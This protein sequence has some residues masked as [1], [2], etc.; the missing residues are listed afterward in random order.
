MI[1]KT[2]LTIGG[3]AVLFSCATNGSKD[4]TINLDTVETEKTIT[5]NADDQVKLELTTNPTTGYDWVTDE[6][7]DCSVKIVDKSNVKT[8]AEGVMGAPSKNVYVVKANQKGECTIRF[9][10]KRSWE[11]EEPTNSKEITFIVK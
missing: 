5:L 1:K 8:T 9:D 2:L 11:T 10:Y 4:K 6:P 3:S 7:E